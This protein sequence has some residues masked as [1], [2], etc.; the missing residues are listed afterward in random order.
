MKESALKKCEAKAAAGDIAARAE[1][2]ELAE[3]LAV[4]PVPSMPRLL[5]DD[6][7]AEAIEI[8]LAA[9]GGRL[10]VAGC[11]GG[12]FDTM[13]GRYSSGVANLDC[14]LK[15]HAGDDLRVDRVTRGS[16]IVDRVCLTL[17]YAVQGEILRGMASQRAFRGRGLVG[18]FLYAMPESPLGS[19]RIDPEP[20]A[21]D[22]ANHYENVVRRLSEIPEQ[23][24]GPGV[25]TMSP[26]AAVAFKSWATEV[27]AM[28]G[29][30][31]R[32][33]SFR[34][35]GGKLVGLTARLAGVIHLV[36]EIDAVDPVAVPIC[37]EVIEAAITLAR[38]AIDHAEAAIGLMAADDGSVDDASYVLRWLRQRA[39]PE[40][41]RRDVAQHGRARFDGDGARL[42]RALAVL[43]DRGWLRPIGD[44]RQGPGRP[45]VRYQCHPSVAAGVVQL[46]RPTVP[47]WESL[48]RVTGVI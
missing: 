41:S 3:Q 21:D 30:D 40:V 14:F 44:D 10:F 34:D 28:L 8:T 18:R 26:S 24:D 29:D 39:E 13:A 47:P 32:L 25:I 17:C 15:G 11:E 42:D 43:V 23:F 38:W 16:L 31:G 1:A 22:V 48:D 46:D 7:T 6:A 35:W 5:V 20:V 27:E 4:E 36:R 12:I 37:V 45:S 2:L 9:Q 33:S 19:R